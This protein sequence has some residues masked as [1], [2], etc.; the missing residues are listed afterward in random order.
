MAEQ[1]MTIKF[2]RQS[3]IISSALPDRHP[4]LHLR[5]DLAEQPDDGG[6]VDENRGR[7]IPA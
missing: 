1:K 2:P 3:I 6:T 4:H 5:G 7:P